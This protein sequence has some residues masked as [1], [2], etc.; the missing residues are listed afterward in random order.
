MDPLIEAYLGVYGIGDSIDK[1]NQIS[2]L[3]KEEIEYIINTLV[4]E[5]FA[6][7][8]DGAKCI[9]EAM[10]DEWLN[11]ILQE[12]PFDVYRGSTE[13][14]GMKVGGEPVKINR[15]PYKTKKGAQRAADKENENYGAGIHSVVRIPEK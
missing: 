3:K 9:L 7:D 1:E 12:A 2:E 4:S 13:Y 8:Y 6:V 11:C 15:K 10:S 5:G 14:D